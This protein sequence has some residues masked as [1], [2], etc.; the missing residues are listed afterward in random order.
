M[1]HRKLAPLIPLALCLA[2]APV[3]G[4][5]AADPTTQ[6]E[7]TAEAAGSR[8]ARAAGRSCATART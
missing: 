6:E 8:A 2:F 4:A 7:A 1:R 5:S 3:Q